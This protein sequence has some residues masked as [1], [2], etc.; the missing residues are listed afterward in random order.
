M[1]QYTC[2]PLRSSRQPVNILMLTQEVNC[3][4]LTTQERYITGEGR[5]ASP[6]LVPVKNHKQ[7]HTTCR[8]SYKS[9]GQ[10]SQTGITEPT[11]GPSLS[12]PPSLFSVSSFWR[13]SNRL[14]VFWQI[15]ISM[16]LCMLQK[17]GHGRINVLYVPL[18]NKD[19]T[20]SRFRPYCSEHLKY[21]IEKKKKT[22]YNK[23]KETRNNKNCVVP[24]CE[25][26]EGDKSFTLL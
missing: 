9:V 18:T 20:W 1:K 14:L 16:H 23:A 12:N 17:H 3:L 6:L 5:F 26:S 22:F 25:K 10:L 2:S 13:L 15:Y 24:F 19:I 4:N 8:V 21:Q 11:A 7:N